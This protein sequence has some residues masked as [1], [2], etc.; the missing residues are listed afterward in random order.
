MSL[1]SIFQH[2]YF[3][4]NISINLYWKSLHHV[5]AFIDSNSQITNDDIIYYEELMLVLR[6]N[7]VHFTDHGM[8]LD[9]YKTVGENLYKNSHTLIEYESEI[10]LIGTPFWITSIRELIH[11]ESKKEDCLNF[12]NYYNNRWNPQFFTWCVAGP[13]AIAAYS[14]LIVDPLWDL[15]WKHPVDSGRYYAYSLIPNT[16]HDGV[17]ITNHTL[18][19]S[20]RITDDTAISNVYRNERVEHVHHFYVIYHQLG[21]LP[22]NFTQIIEFG[23]GTGDNVPTLRNLNFTGLHLIYDLLPVLLLQQ[24]FLRISGYPAYLDFNDT[25]KYDNSKLQRRTLLKPVNRF[26]S[27]IDNLD[28]SNESK[29]TTLFMA[30]FS[31]TETPLEYRAPFISK[32]LEYRPMVIYITMFNTFEDMNNLQWLNDILIPQMTE[33]GYTYRLWN[34]GER[35]YFIAS[36][37]SFTTADNISKT[38]CAETALKSNNCWNDKLIDSDMTTE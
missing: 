36:L 6:E 24:Y 31:L 33:I 19:S 37:K 35:Y 21:L 28:F 20:F 3:D 23:G 26:S 5:E 7:M 9:R 14:L 32:L 25:I 11:H 16:I 4:L 34:T 2:N 12:Y 1:S 15:V 10:V 29:A 30:T 8:I 17:N 18:I 38:Q 27:L 13:F 22:N